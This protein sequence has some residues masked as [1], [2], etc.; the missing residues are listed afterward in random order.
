MSRKYYLLLLG[1][2]LVLSGCGEGEKQEVTSAVVMP[3]AQTPE[4]TDEELAMPLNTPISE[5][6][7]KAEP[8]PDAQPEPEQVEDD[9]PVSEVS[10]SKTEDKA[11]SETESGIRELEWDDLMPKDYRIE[12]LLAKINAGDISDDDPRID[13]AMEKVKAMFAQAPVV[14]ELHNQE[15]KLPGFVVPMDSDNEKITD[16]LLVPYYGAC[17]HVPPPPA[18]QTVFVTGKESKY[19]LYD[20]VWVTGK[21]VVERN[22]NELGDS[23]Y[24]IIASDISPYE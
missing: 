19:K 13:E 4:L 8:E 1:G 6:K 11:A 12:E 3:E 21:I 7:T 2:L 9:Q 14:D 10:R 16:F 24:S 20:T 18:N 5:V 23:G 22:Q 17:I 15:I